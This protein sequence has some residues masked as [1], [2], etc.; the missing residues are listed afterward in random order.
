MKPPITLAI[1]LQ[2]VYRAFVAEWARLAEEIVIGKWESN[3]VAFGPNRSDAMWINERLRVLQRALDDLWRNGELE[4]R[5]AI[6]GAKVSAKNA[7]GVESVLRQHLPTLKLRDIGGFPEAIDAFRK[8]NVGLIK[9]LQGKQLEEIRGIL[10]KAEATGIRVEVLRS[11]LMDRFDVS[12]SRAD[13]IARDQVLK[14][15][16]ELTEKRQ[17]QAGISRYK[18]STS[19]DERV[20]DMHD[21]LDDKEF[22]WDDPPVTDAKG[23]RNHPGGDYQCRCIAI[24]ILD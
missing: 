15:N 21:D 7:K 18:W 6:T 8:R 5:I 19:N 13:L 10:E 9:T 16:G 14:L 3:P 24:P 22:S 2:R 1:S 12:K 4:K 20:R 23:N 17:T 11:Q